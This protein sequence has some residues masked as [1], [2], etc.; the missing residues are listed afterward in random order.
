[1]TS[2]DAG[3][4]PI[5]WQS[6]IRLPRCFTGWPRSSS[7]KFCTRDATAL[8]Q[9]LLLWFNDGNACCLGW[10]PF[11]CLL[12]SHLDRSYYPSTILLCRTIS[13]VHQKPRGSTCR[14]SIFSFAISTRSCSALHSFLLK[15]S[16]TQL[17]L[18]LAATCR[19]WCKGK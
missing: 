10:E 15:H 4:T 2:S 18:P 5:W 9:Q 14:S 17:A 11:I 16:D 1:M 7:K 6:R 19:E 8:P 12:S 3:A 13:V